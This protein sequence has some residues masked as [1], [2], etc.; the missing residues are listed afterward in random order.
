MDHRLTLLASSR[1]DLTD[2]QRTLRGAIE[3]SYELLVDKE[4]TFFR[5]FAAFAGGTDFERA[6]AVIDPTFEVGDV[7]DL[8]AALVDR[9]LLRSIETADGNRLAMLETIREFAADRLAADASEHETLLRRHAEVYEALAIAHREVL[10]R[11]DRDAA[12]ARL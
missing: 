11:P 4:R 3:W 1:R 7:L 10:T 8:G 6:Q 12:L 9:S 5:R 2:R